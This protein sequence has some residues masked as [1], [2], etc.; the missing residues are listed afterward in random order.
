MV[1]FLLSHGAD[2]N[3]NTTSGSARAL[4]V[5]AAVSSIPVLDALINAGAELKG[6][7]ALPKAARQGRTEVVAHLL[8]RG[9]VIDEVPD[10]DDILENA[11]ELGVKNAL[12]M[13]A[14]QGQTEVLKMLLERGADVG[15]KDTNGRSALELA[16]SEG[17]ESCVDVL[18]EHSRAKCDK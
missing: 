10:N 16:E 5:A 15:I 4:E 8:A 13:A 7:S 18:K 11:R 6:R 1:Q 17:H 12:C 14:W 2:P 9:A 3:T